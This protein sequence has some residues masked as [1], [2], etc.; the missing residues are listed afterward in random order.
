MKRITYIDIARAFA[1]IFIVIGHTLVHS[2]HCSLVFKFLYSFHVLLFFILSGYTFKIKKEKFLIYV[3][4]KF[5]RIMIPYFVWALLFLIPYM[6]FGGT[7]EESIGTSSSFDLKTQI[8]NILYG[9]GNMSALKQNSSLWFL[10]ALFT[11]EIVYYFVI[12]L[13]NKNRKLQIPVLVILLALS[14]I[15]NMFFPIILPWGINTVLELGIFFYVG[16]L[17]IYQ[18]IFDNK[19]KLCDNSF[20]TFILTIGLLACF[21]NNHN[22]SCIEYEYGNFTLALISGLTL[23]IFTIYIAYL[24]NKNKFLEYIGQNTMGILV[25]HKLII[26]VFQTKLGVISSMLENSNIVIEV[27]LTIVITSLSIFFSLVATEITKKIM[28]CLVGE[29]MENKIPKHS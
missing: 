3:K 23:S 24:I 13:I 17:L 15:T 27:L 6:L 28:P 8:I 9:N 7:V 26:L 22:V 2:Q 5:I 10:P 4:N 1:I 18:N 14:Y 29:K 25:F 16:Y 19:S 21:L 11:M 20:I 12:N